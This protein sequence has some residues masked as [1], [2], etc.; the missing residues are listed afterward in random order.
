MKIQ[1]VCDRKIGVLNY[2]IGTD[3]AENWRLIDAAQQT[4]LWFHVAD[5]PSSHVVLA[6]P[7]GA[8]L[9]HVTNQ[10]II[11]CATACIQRSSV[12]S[13]RGKIKV[14]YTTMANLSKAATLGSVEI[15]DHSLLH[16]ISITR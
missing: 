12:K 6:L 1:T 11:C 15:N 2:K 4:D 3:A 8:S 5:A 9:K 7:D 14:S 16:E 13:C 10:T